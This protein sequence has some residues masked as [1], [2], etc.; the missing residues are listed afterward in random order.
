[1]GEG[2]Q[3]SSPHRTKIGLDSSV[4][5]PTHLRDVLCERK[6]PS[7]NFQHGILEGLRLSP[8]LLLLA[9]AGASDANCHHESLD[10][11]AECYDIIL[12]KDEEIGED[13]SLHSRCERREKQTQSE[14]DNFP[15]N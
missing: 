3:E 8:G 13:R 4:A 7:R 6:C 1:M 15:F 11:H 9:V 2:R 10:L 14:P 5:S 12:E